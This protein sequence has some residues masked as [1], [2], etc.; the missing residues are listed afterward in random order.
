MLFFGCCFLLGSYFC[1]DNPGPIEETL[2]KD[3]D[4]STV[5]FNL[6][7][8]VYSYPN[9]VLPI[10]G[11][12]FLDMIGMRL[13]IIVFTTVLTLGQ[14]IFTLGGYRKSLGI[15]IAGRVVFGLGGESLSA[16]QSA[17]VSKWFKGKELA[18]ALGLNISISRM[19]SVV[20]GIVIPQIYNSTHLDRLGLALLV[21][22]FVCVF[23]EVC[24]VFL[25]MLDKRADTVDKT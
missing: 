16:A 17:I 18:M 21:G 6:L 13:G 3:L 9:T 24:A 4:I 5:Q 22:F 11:G 14:A 23:S 10:F 1:Y 12:I 25:I 7:Y 20:N 8:S 2:E 19:G 15:M